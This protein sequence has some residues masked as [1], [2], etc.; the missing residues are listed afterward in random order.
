MRRKLQLQELAR[1]LQRL[2]D[3]K[4]VGNLENLNDGAACSTVATDLCKIRVM[5]SSTIGSINLNL[6]SGNGGC[7]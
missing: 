7:D 2:Q 5:V 1:P 6:A 3:S 4:D